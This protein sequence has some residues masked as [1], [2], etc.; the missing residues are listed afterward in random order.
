VTAD[1]Q[2]VALRF[3]IGV[4]HLVVEELRVLWPSGNAPL[5]VVEQAA[6][7]TELAVLVKNLD[8]HEVAQLAR[9]CLHA[10][11]ELR[12]VALDLRAQQRLHAVAD[13]LRLQLSARASGIAEE[14]RECGHQAGL[15]ARAFEQDAIED[16]D[17]IEVVALRLEELLALLDGRLHDWIVVAGKREYQADST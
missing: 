17:L 6:E 3:K 1:A 11:A 8:L 16:F 9:E 15:R 7:E 2:M 13:K 12:E 5:I 4:D 14:A 10:L